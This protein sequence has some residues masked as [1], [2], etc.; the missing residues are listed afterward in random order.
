MKCFNTRCRP[1]EDL[2]SGV[3]AYEPAEQRQLVKKD[4]AQ[5]S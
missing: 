1:N 4:F 5:K 2:L 3:L